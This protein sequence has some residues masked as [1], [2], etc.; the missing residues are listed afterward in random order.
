M[1]IVQFKNGK[2]GVRRRDSL[3]FWLDFEFLSRNG[4]WGK[5]TTPSVDHHYAFDSIDEARL[6][7]KKS[8]EQE[9][10]LNNIWRDKGRKIKS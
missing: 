1:K 5:I 4:W 8:K 10:R 3:E 9:E 7:I 2:Y 6:I